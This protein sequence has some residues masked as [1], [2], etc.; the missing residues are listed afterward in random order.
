[1]YLDTGKS[2]KKTWE[3]FYK[4]FKPQILEHG[5]DTTQLGQTKSSL[6][7]ETVKMKSR[8]ESLYTLENDIGYVFRNKA[9]LYYAATPSPAFEL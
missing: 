5:I 8:I 7:E 1:V 2:T 6:F 9:L 4:Y 3:V